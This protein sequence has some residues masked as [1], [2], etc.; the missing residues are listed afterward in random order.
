MVR[1]MVRRSC[2]VLITVLA[3]SCTGGGNPQSQGWFA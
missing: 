1:R 3:V 2:A